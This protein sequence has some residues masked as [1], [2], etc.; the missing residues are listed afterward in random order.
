L[1]RFLLAKLHFDSLIGKRSPKAVRAALKNLA[2]G[3]GAYDSAYHDAMERIQG[4]IGDQEE[5]AKQVLSWI[6]C[7]KRPLTT[8]ELRHALAVEQDEPAL[9]KSNLPETED[10]VSVC[11]GLVTVDEESG[12]IRLVHYTT[13]EFFKRTHSQWFPHA[14]LEITTAC[15]TYLSFQC[16]GTGPCQTDVDYEERLGSHP[17]YNYAAHNWG[18]HGRAASTCSGIMA[19]LKRRAQVEAASQA[20]LVAERWMH[21]SGYS[22]RAS[23]K[24]TGLHLAAYYG[25]TKTVDSILDEHNVEAKDTC[26]QTPLSYAAENGHTDVVQLLIEKGADIE[27]KDTS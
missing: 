16:F 11:A 13:Q 4:Q 15:T 21:V 14:Q 20:M 10:I 26:G 12:V 3:S 25:L 18:H 17:L 1:T 7:A 6:T 22:E 19:F 8:L 2:T 24:M 27:T 5:L 23:K 9:D